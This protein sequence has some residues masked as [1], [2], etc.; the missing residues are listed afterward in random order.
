MAVAHVAI[1]VVGSFAKN[2]AQGALECFVQGLDLTLFLGLG[3]GVGLESATK[4]RAESAT[5]VNGNIKD[6]IVEIR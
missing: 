3:L 1:D 4:V 6:K 2:I 5:K